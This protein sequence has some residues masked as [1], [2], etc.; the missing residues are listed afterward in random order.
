MIEIDTSLATPQFQHMADQFPSAIIKAEVD[1]DV[2]SVVDEHSSCSR[3]VMTGASDEFVHSDDSYSNNEEEDQQHQEDEDVVPVSVEQALYQ[4]IKAEHAEQRQQQQ[5]GEEEKEE[6]S[7]SSPVSAIANAIATAIASEEP[8]ATKSKSILRRH[9]EPIPIHAKR[10]AWKVLPKPDMERLSKSISNPEGGFFE[11]GQKRRTSGVI[12]KDVLIREYHQ[13]VGDN[14]CVSYG[15]P[16]SL[17]W[18][19]EEF[20]SVTLDE[21]EG[22]RGQRR[23]LRQMILSYYQRRNVLSWQYGVSPEDLKLAKR[24]A[25]KCKSER[26]VTNFLLPYMLVEAA[27]E[28]AQRKAKRLLGGK[29][30]AQKDQQQQQLPNNNSTTTTTP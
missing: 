13:T 29:Q 6:E 25:N 5:I 28:S 15:P 21:Y 20:E 30:Q 26:A 9:S 11:K 4:Q 18:D 7:S 19:Y 12:F 16:I 10:N 14:P 8:P 17:D 3:T 24:K 23:N 1:V 27:L 2:A 22:S